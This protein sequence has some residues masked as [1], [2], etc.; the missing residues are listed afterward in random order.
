MTPRWIHVNVHDHVFTLPDYWEAEI[1]FCAPPCKV[2]RPLKLNRVFRRQSCQTHTS[3]VLPGIS[4]GKR[5]KKNVYKKEETAGRREAWKFQEQLMFAQLSP[6]DS[7][8]LGHITVWTYPNR[9]GK[10]F[11]AH[12]SDNI[13]VSCFKLKSKQGHFHDIFMPLN[14]SWWTHNSAPEC[15]LIHALPSINK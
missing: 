15:N 11:T 3:T 9:H 8:Q 12:I 1:C 2:I 6:P 4:I 10:R 13:T 7:V 14:A 5:I